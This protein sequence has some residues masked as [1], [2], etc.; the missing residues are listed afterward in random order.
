MATLIETATKLLKTH[1]TADK[2]LKD[3]VLELKKRENLLHEIAIAYLQTCKPAAKPA[4][5]KPTQADGS[6]QVRDFEVPAY[7]RRTHE[8][9]QAAL[10]AAGRL[11]DSVYEAISI[12]GTAIGEL[13]WGELRT[14]VAEHAMSAASHLREGKDAT[15][16]AI[17][18][19]KIFDYASVP[20]TRAKIRDVV[21]A[22]KIREMIEEASIEAPMFIEKFMHRY[23]ESL[24]SGEP[25]AIEA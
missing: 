2:A 19:R 18:L 21:P 12:R 7:R 14:L 11:A 13:R 10:A 1:G 16:N 3:F 4:P 8:E 23:A 25:P 20:D 5:A 24:K 22:A 9:K 15:A 17:L 6:V